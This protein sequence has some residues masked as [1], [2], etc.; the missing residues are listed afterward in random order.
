MMRHDQQEPP[1]NCHLHRRAEAS[2]VR[3]QFHRSLYG[4]VVLWPLA[5]GRY[6]LGTGKWTPKWAMHV[7]G[8]AFTA[9]LAV[10]AVAVI[11]GWV[12]AWRMGLRL[13]SQGVTVRNYFRTTGSTGLR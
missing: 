5:A 10:V 12:R 9:V 6:R 1:G 7:A 3:D 8:T 11:C 2:L 4:A 13:D